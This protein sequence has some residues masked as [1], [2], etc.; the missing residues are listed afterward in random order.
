MPDPGLMRQLIGL[1]DTVSF[2]VYPRVNAAASVNTLKAEPAWR[3]RPSVAGSNCDSANVWPF[4]MAR[5]PPSLLSIATSEAVNSDFGRTSFIAD[6]AAN[7][8]YGSYAV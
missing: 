4:A 2:G 6:C 1:P 8:T 5:T 3:P 7:C